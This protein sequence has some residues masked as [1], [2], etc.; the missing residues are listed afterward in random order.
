MYKFVYGTYEANPLLAA[1][2]HL[3]E[4]NRWWF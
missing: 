1:A 4:S 2:I 3:T